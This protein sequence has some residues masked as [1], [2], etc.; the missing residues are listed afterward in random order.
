MILNFIECNIENNRN[1]SKINIG[2]WA[3]APG[4]YLKFN[5]ECKICS[6]RDV[7]EKYL[8]QYDKN[9]HIII[10]GG[11][12][13]NSNRMSQIIII[14]NYFVGI[15][16]LWGADGSDFNLIID[17]FDILGVRSIHVYNKY[18]D[19]YNIHYVPCASCMFKMFK[20]FNSS[21]CLIIPEGTILYGAKKKSSRNF[22]PEM[23]N[24]YEIVT[25]RGRD[26]FDKITQLKTHKTVITNSYHGYFWCL[27]LNKTPNIDAIQHPSLFDDETH[28]TNHER[29]SKYINEARE[30]KKLGDDTQFYL[31]YKTNGLIYTDPTKINALNDSRNR[32]IEF[33]Q[34]VEKLIEDFKSQPSNIIL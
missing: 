1:P 6:L 21:K 3:S 18:K 28:I 8:E 16:V 30:K 32:N 24:K 31:E 34:K 25:N 19:Q 10:G 9:T 12:I 4:R 15:K 17:K 11:G 29:R 7:T 13:I 2:D 33:K 26:L 23:R 14:L 20:R 22:T 27:L 5:D